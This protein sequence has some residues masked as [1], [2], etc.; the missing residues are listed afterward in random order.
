MGKGLRLLGCLAVVLLGCG[1]SWAA[2]GARAQPVPS[3]NLKSS[4]VAIVD[5]QR[6]LQASGAAKS[7]QQQLETQRSKFQTEIAAEEADLRDA[8]QKLSKLRE[9]A[10]TDDYLEQEQKLQQRFLTVERHVQA[11]RKAL[12]QA[13]TDSMNIVRKALIDIVSEI[14]TL[15]GVNL[16]IVKQQVI[17]NDQNIDITDE[18]LTRLD[19]ALPNVQVNIVAEEE[20]AEKPVLVRPKGQKTPPSKNK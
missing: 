17:W 8:E 14:A 6:I 13:N 1:Q 15:R 11:R 3:G 5:V 12:D 10:K 9:T 2:E 4:I 18:V 7:V 19:K 16:V 20:T